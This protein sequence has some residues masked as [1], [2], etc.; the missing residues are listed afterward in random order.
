ML[1][2]FKLLESFLYTVTL[3]AVLTPVSFG[4]KGNSCTVEHLLCRTWQAGTYRMENSFV[5]IALAA[6]GKPAFPQ[7]FDNI[8]AI[9][10]LEPELGKYLKTQFEY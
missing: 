8:V 1:Q 5:C 2:V 4:N 3:A 10:L 9:V 7:S 6:F